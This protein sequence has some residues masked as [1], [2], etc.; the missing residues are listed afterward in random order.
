MNIEERV[1]AGEYVNHDPYPPWVWE[2]SEWPHSQA[3]SVWH[4]KAYALAS[5]FRSDAAL[6]FGLQDNRI[7]NYAWRL[8]FGGDVTHGHTQGYLEVIR[9]LIALVG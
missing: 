2:S 4:S 1:R 3:R 7:L 8:A 5:E 9:H 6:A